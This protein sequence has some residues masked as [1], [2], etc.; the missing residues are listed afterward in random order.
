MRISLLLFL[1]LPFCTIA[2]T[3]KTSLWLSAEVKRELFKNFTA[4]IEANTRF[5]AIPGLETTFGEISA[6]YKVTKWFKPSIAYRVIGSKNK[7]G[8]TTA[9]N[10]V[11]V[12]LD[13][14]Y[15]VFKR[16][17]AGFRLRYQHAIYSANSSGS[18][19][20][21]EKSLR[22]KPEF[23]Y[24]LKKSIFSPSVSAEWFYSLS[25]G[26]KQNTFTRYRLYL[27]SAIDLKKNNEVN[28]NL[29]YGKTFTGT[30]SQEWILS[31]S[32]SYEWKKKKAKK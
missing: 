6:A 17:D 10:R 8:N 9:S 3:D 16:L 24:H 27:G 20:E 4:S 1:C 23:T 7:Y 30:R 31:L 15:E 12:N 25:P 14:K 22:I 28:V 11:N 26:P 18:S 21:F 19:S 2:Q 13:F 5:R 32:Y 29:I